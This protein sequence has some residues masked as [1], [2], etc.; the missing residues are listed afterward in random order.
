MKPVYS[1][2]NINTG[3]HIAGIC[4]ILITPREWVATDT[5]IDFNTGRILEPVTLLDNKFW[6]LLNLIDNTYTYDEN[7][8]ASKTTSFEISCSGTLNNYHYALQQVLQTFSL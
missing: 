3:A 1:D 8:K 7:P 2:I 6:M 5:V 4:Q